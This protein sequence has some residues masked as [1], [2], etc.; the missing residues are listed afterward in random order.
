MVHR[1][2]RIPQA[3]DVVVRVVLLGVES[4]VPE[5]CP[6]LLGREAEKPLP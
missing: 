2:R 1:L 5:L 3:R 4:G 6:H